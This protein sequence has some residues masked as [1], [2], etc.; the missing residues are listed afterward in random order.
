MNYFYIRAAYEFVRSKI[1][2][3]EFV[4]LFYLLTHDLRCN[5]FVNRTI[6]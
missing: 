2:Y 5:L 3:C 6:F 4:N 1:G